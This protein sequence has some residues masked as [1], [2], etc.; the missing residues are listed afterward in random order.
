MLL[1]VN[2]HVIG[3]AII[4]A[5]LYCSRLQ[6]VQYSTIQYSAVKEMHDATLCN[7]DATLVADKTSNA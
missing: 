4:I 7:K 2:L 5:V 6:Y 3:R 1:F